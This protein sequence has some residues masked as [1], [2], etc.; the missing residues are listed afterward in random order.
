MRIKKLPQ[1]TS[2]TLEVL[3]ELINRFS[4]DRRSMMLSCNVANLTAQISR[5]RNK[6]VKIENEEITGT[7]KY[8]REYFF[9]RYK[10]KNREDQIKAIEIYEEL[11]KNSLLV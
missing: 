9:V 4:I 1:P 6:G 3:Y 5:L 7:N 8:G 2:Q 10:F 11:I